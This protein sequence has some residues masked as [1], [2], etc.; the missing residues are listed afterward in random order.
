M[1][2]Q[3]IHL[4]KIRARIKNQDLISGHKLNLT[5][6]LLL[7]GLRKSLRVKNKTDDSEAWGG[8]V[9][10]TWM[11]SYWASIIPVWIY[12]IVYTFSM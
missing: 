2:W 6:K 7:E 12:F 11:I 4:R 9:G 10:M 5:W 8:T 1:P 3:L